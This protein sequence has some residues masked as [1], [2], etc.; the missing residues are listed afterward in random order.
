MR[1]RTPS[2]TT[3]AKQ[4][5]PER[6]KATKSIT[7]SQV[8]DKAEKLQGIFI[9]HVPFRQSWQPS[10]EVLLKHNTRVL[11]VGDAQQR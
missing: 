1:R 6:T 9:C 7:A 5:P 11:P 3:T 10:R 4:D 2:P 8:S